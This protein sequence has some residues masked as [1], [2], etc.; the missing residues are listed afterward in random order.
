[1]KATFHTKNHSIDSMLKSSVILN[2]NNEI[3]AYFELKWPKF[4]LQPSKP[5]KF[6]T[7]PTLSLLYQSANVCVYFF[8]F[9]ELYS[10]SRWIC[11]ESW[12]WRQKKYWKTQKCN[13]LIKPID[14]LV[15][16]TSDVLCNF[17]FIFHWDDAWSN[18][19]EIHWD[20]A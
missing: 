2:W 18:W 17:V 20:D 16:S 7:F 15:K 4:N 8:S 3:P 10:T 14:L 13:N 12:L 9:L 5:L 6:N 19:V 1:M 11:A